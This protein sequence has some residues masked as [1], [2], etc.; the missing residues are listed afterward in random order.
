MPLSTTAWLTSSSE[1]GTIP[2]SFRHSIWRPETPRNTE[3]IWQS[4]IISAS[5]TARCSDLT[6]DSRSLTPPLSMPRAEWVPRPMMLISPSGKT[7]P[8]N[9]ATLVVPISSPTIR[10]LSA[11]L[12]IAS[13]FNWFPSYSDPGVVTHVEVGDSLALLQ[14]RIHI[15][16]AL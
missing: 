16:E 9:T 10:F 15:D 4:A 2:F 7:S 12:V 6:T 3:E 14:Q 13:P 8:T 11:V 1:L 5:S